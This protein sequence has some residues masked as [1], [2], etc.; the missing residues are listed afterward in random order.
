MFRLE[1]NEAVWKEYDR[2][3]MTP[4]KE[5]VVKKCEL[6]SFL[7]VGKLAGQRWS[8]IGGGGDFICSAV[9]PSVECRAVSINSPSLCRSQT[10]LHSRDRT[11]TPLR[12]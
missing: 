6:M 12:D 11:R 5:I 3:E 2:Q 1:G 9:A 8:E 7:V 4:K 10:H